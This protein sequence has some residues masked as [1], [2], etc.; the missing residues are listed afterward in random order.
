MSLVVLLTLLTQIILFVIVLSIVTRSSP[1]ALGLRVIDQFARRLR[2][3]PVPRLSR[4]TPQLYVGGQHARHG[5]GQMQAM[6][7]TAV[8]NLREAR[9][10]D[11]ARG[12]APER[13]DSYLRMR[14]GEDSR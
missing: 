7:I 3:A 9:Y 5:W 11:R 13:Y 12:I 2:G 14:S 8:V 6:G 1:L 10:D 4:V